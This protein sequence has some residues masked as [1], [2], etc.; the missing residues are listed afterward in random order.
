MI[1]ECNIESQCTTESECKNSENRNRL[2]LNIIF[3]P[4]NFITFLLTYLSCFKQKTNCDSFTSS[5]IIFL[6][7]LLSSGTCSVHDIFHIITIY[8][9]IFIIDFFLSDNILSAKKEL[10][11]INATFFSIRHLKKSNKSLA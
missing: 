4:E 5:H 6:L 8:T 9:W 7:S 10:G 11:Q 1:I 2:H 3:I